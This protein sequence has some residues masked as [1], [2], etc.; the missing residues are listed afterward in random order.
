M[1]ISVDKIGCNVVVSLPVQYN[2]VTELTSSDEYDDVDNKVFVFD[3][4][5][6]WDKKRINIFEMPDYGLVMRW[7]YTPDMVML[8][9]RPRFIYFKDKPYILKMTETFSVTTTNTLTKV[10][11]T[12]NEGVDRILQTFHPRPFIPHKH[13]VDMLRDLKDNMLRQF[14]TI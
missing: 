1:S 14:I 11:F 9:D 7:Y 13:Y 4:I 3:G 8:G 2:P 6:V 10:H 12:N 5:N